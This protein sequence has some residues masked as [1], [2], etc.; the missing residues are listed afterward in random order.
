MDKDYN[1]FH[2]PFCNA[3]VSDYT[4]QVGESERINHPLRS[5]HGER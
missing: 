5:R 1:L 3:E 2:E 4:K